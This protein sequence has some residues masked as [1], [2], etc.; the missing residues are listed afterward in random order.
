MEVFWFVGLVF[1]IIINLYKLYRKEWL[2]ASVV[3][4]VTLIAL[5]PRPAEHCLFLDSNIPFVETMEASPK[6]ITDTAMSGKAILLS[7]HNMVLSFLFHILLYNPDSLRR[8]T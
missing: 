8:L 1:L 2:F 3:L 5:L 6:E 4:G 7:D